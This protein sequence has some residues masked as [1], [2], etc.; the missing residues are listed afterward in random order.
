MDQLTIQC[1]LFVFF[2]MIV[3]GVL[4]PP[5]AMFRRKLNS[6]KNMCDSLLIDVTECCND[7]IPHFSKTHRFG[8]DENLEDLI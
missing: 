1:I 4:L 7:T 6:N 8:R 2:L 5:V 3:E